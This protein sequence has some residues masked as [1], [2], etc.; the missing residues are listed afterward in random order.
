MTART[1]D[2]TIAMPRL[3]VGVTRLPTPGLLSRD[4]LHDLAAR[5]EDFDADHGIGAVLLHGASH[6]FCGGLD[7][8]EFADP[9]GHGDLAAALERC[10]L[11]FA[12]LGKPLVVSVDGL[13][14]GFGATM[15]CHADVVVASERSRIRMPFLDLGLFPEA[16]STLLLGERIGHLNAFRMI[17][18]A[19]EIDA[20]E[21]KQFGLVTKVEPSATVEARAADAASCLARRP[22]NLLVAAKDLM[23][24]PREDLVER[25][26]VE[27][28]LCLERLRDPDVRKRLS[29]ISAIKRGSRS[30]VTL[31]TTAA[32]CE[33]A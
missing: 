31:A 12:R 14:C 7:L 3:G 33:I 32:G 24:R 5:L 23:K 11:A 8:D 21:A 2:T 22:A 18:L 17:C 15:L 19:E 10:F 27:V 6:D 30:R 26:K 28:A 4:D 29:R 20:A 9:D 13:A 25:I 1:A 16:G